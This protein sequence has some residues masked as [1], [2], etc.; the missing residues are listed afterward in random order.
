[1]RTT[2]PIESPA[3]SPWMRFLGTSAA[4]LSAAAGRVCRSLFRS[5]RTY[6]SLERLTDRE[7]RD[8][9][10]RRDMLDPTAYGEDKDSECGLPPRPL[11]TA[12]MLL[13]ARGGA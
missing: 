3:P 7:L 5:S 8:M 12:L 10:L 13:M 1:M 6:N 2:D 4:Q 9:G 11:V